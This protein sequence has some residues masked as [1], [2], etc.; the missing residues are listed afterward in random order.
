MKKT[1]S[2]I[3]IALTFGF[4]QLLL[5]TT[6]FAE[7]ESPAIS[8]SISPVSQRVILRAGETSEHVFTMANQGSQDFSFSAYAAPFSVSGENYEMS[9]AAENNRTQISRWISFKQEDGTYAEKATY[10]VPKGEKKEIAYKVTVP[11]D[12]PAGGQYAA[13]FAEVS[14]DDVEANAG[15]IK[16]VPRLSVIIFGRTDGETKLEAAISE[17][18]VSGFVIPNKDPKATKGHIRVSSLINNTG[19]TDLSA[20]NEFQVSTLFGKNLYQKEVDYPVY[21]EQPRRITLEMVDTPSFGLFKVHYKI[22]AEDKSIDRTT[23]VLVMPLWLIILSIIL[24]TI[25]IAWT[26]IKLKQRK[27]RAARQ[28]I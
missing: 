22:T 1:F 24:L 14:A 17:Y 20:K 28:M 27:D 21:P 9:F 13:V 19:N 8:P 5:P 23:L 10:K 25:I 26:I 6:A 11:Q 3:I 7:G 2:S 18:K 12:V 16:T 15:G 4:S